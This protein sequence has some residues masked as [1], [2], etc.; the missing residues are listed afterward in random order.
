M[1]LST[2]L[3]CS[4]DNSEAF[5]SYNDRLDVSASSAT[6]NNLVPGAV[7]S[8]RMAAGNDVGVGEYSSTHAIQTLPAGKQ[9]LSFSPTCTLCD[10][11]HDS[12]CDVLCDTSCD[13]HTDNS[14]CDDTSC[15][16]A[17]HGNAPRGNVM[18]DDDLCDM[19]E[20]VLQRHQ[21]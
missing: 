13:I 6:I 11:L 4:D 9:S 15:D 5:E 20:F 3:S 14:P 16:N 19:Y 21:M 8:V 1:I 10:S 17:L 18:C 12:R 7:Y 2:A